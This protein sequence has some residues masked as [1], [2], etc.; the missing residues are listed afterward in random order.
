M[1]YTVFT[2]SRQT[3]N[4]RDVYFKKVSDVY[5]Q[6]LLI[7]AGNQDESVEKWIGSNL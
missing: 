5:L 7:E 1:I 3:D 2:Q 6:W 4:E